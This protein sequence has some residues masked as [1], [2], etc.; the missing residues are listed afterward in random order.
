MRIK[1]LYINDWNV[2]REANF[3][4]LGDLVVIAGPN[5]VGKT[6]IKNA[7]C[8]IFQ[9]NGN[10]PPNCRVTLQAT[11]QSERDAWKKEDFSLPFQS[12]WGFFSQET[13]KIKTKSRLIQI[14]ADRTIDTIKFKQLTFDQ[15][16][17][18]ENEVIGY[19]YGF[20]SVKNRFIDICKTLHR[21]K[22]REITN[23]YQEYSKKI[24]IDSQIV[25]FNRVKDP[26]EKYRELFNNLL[27]PKKMCP[28]ELQSTTIQYIDTDGSKRDFSSLSSGEKEIV[29]VIF[30]LC[31]QNPSNCIILIDEPELH[32]HPE[33][34]FRFLNTLS[35]VGEQNQIF[36]FTHSV[37]I[38]GSSLENGVYFLR[39]KN[40]VA[41]GN[42]VLRIDKETLP[43]L[44]MIPNLRETIGMISVGK[45]VVFVEGGTGSIDRNVF[46]LIAK[47]K[48]IDM[49]IIPSSGCAN[50][51]NMGL[52]VSSI[53]S[54][55]LGVE[56]HMIRDRDSLTNEM[57]DAYIAKSKGRLHFLPFYH[58]EN[59]FLNVDAIHAVAQSMLFERTP[60]KDEIEQKI[61]QLARSQKNH[62]IS[63]YLKNEIY[64]EAGNFDVSPDIS[65]NESLSIDLLVKNI[66]EKATIH[67]S[68]YSEL[69]T[70]KKISERA[71]FWD[72]ELSNA[73][74]D[75]WSRK[76]QEIV[77]GKRIL[78]EVQ[79]W[80][81]S[82]RAIS[83]WELILKSDLPECKNAL[84]E[85]QEIIDII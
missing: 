35:I 56:F 2:I 75:G 50:I 45:K 60:S 54:G 57:I 76:A 82:S 80:L 69:F 81:F 55:I 73:L 40:I 5:G 26:T 78:K 36:L 83:L 21:L 71:R 63:L 14:D 53:E 47:A 67:I 59:S 85:L 29:I 38:I 52:F 3:E 68:K 74:K 39:Q 30:D 84:L 28:I 46:G 65:L 41:N 17:D 58:I 12:F 22:S 1:N 13:K 11:N 66:S 6:Q 64:F 61:I 51:T 15:I 34:T 25:T 9:N 49:A 23:V 79:N 8:H 24:N 37:D 32:L 10:P 18:P 48:K 72:N 4:N 42:Q 20:S 77:Y 31:T 44:E 27:Y 19:D 62:L 7:I 70:E 33:L 16:G 43:K